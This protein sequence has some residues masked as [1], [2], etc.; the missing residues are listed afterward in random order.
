MEQNNLI[1]HNNNDSNGSIRIPIV[2]EY[3]KVHF[4]NQQNFGKITPPC[5]SM[6]SIFDALL[7]GTTTTNHP[8]CTEK[9]AGPLSSENSSQNQHDD[10][11]TE[12]NEHYNINGR[13]RGWDRGGNREAVRKYRQKK[14]AHTVSLTDEL[15]KLRA[16]NQELMQRVRD[17]A[18]LETEVARLKCLLVDIRGRI[19]GEIGSFPYQKP[20]ISSHDLH[21]NF[22][23][24]NFSGSSKI[25]IDSSSGDQTCLNDGMS[26]GGVVSF[27]VQ[28]FESIPSFGSPPSLG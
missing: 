6:D 8:N 18:S 23:D 19:E 16:L 26:S 5:G 24:T 1:N 25:L 27:N 14:K 3:N 22:G 7:R 28:N 9:M 12:S 17:Q 4:I 2:E 20:V 13:Q 10:Y 15:V 11:S 21:H